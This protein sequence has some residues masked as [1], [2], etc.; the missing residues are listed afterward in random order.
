MTTRTSPGIDILAHIVE[1]A[2]HFRNTLR[3]DETELRQVPADR[4]DQLRPLPNKQIASPVNHQQGLLL[5]AFDRHEAHGWAAHSL[6]DGG[7]I[8]CIVLAASDVRLHVLRRQKS[9][10]V[11]EPAELAC[12]DFAVAQSSIPTRQGASLPK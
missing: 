11:P 1:K 10:I 4:I 7:S 12:P 6:A 2:R 8:G 3:S 9:H 5:L